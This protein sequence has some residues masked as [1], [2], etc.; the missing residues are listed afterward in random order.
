MNGW[1]AQWW[2]RLRI[3]HKVWAVLL[4]LCVPLGA[5]LATHL[6]VVQQLLMLQQQ[7]H[8]L[9]LAHEQVHVLRR[10]AIDI[11]DG[12]RGY[13]LTQQPAFLVPMTDAV[14]KIEQAL[15]SSAASLAKLPDP[16]N[17][18]GP[19]ER[20]LKDLLRSKHELIADIQRGD[21]E[22][23][24]AYVRS[25]EG[26]QLS[27]RLR[28]EL[29]VIE[30]RLEQERDRLNVKAEALSQ[31]TFIG[32][33]IA[34]AGV[35]V[36]GWIGSRMLARSLTDPIRRLQTATTKLGEQID[37][38]EAAELLRPAVTS[39]DELGQLAHAYLTMAHRIGT[40]IQELEV[41][42]TIGQ[43]INT[44][45]PDG[46]DGVLRRITDRAMEL[47]QADVCLMLVRDER[48]GCWIVEAASGEWNDRLK[49]SVMLWEELPVSV[50]AYES[51]EAAVGEHFREDQR[52]QVVRRNLIG[53]SMLAIP[54]LSQGVPFGVLSLLSRQPRAAFEWN[55]RLAKGLAQEAALAISNARLYEAA[56]EK[57]RGL[58]ARLRHL[59]SLAE[60]LAHDLKGPGARMEELSKLLAQKFSG[61]TDERTAKWLALI[62]EN[63]RDIVR[64]VEGILEVAQVGVGQGTVT[65]VDPRL[66]VDDV[67]KAQAGEIER[68]QA[69]I[70]VESG[71]PL[72]AC[73]GA[74][75]RQ[76][77]DNLVTNALKYARP[78]VPPEVTIS[79]QTGKHM[80]CFAVQDRGIGVPAAQRSRVFQPFVRL[81]EATAPGSGIGLTIVQR[82]VEL[83]GG[84]VW[85]DGTD[86]E[87]C[88]VKFTLPSLN[89]DH[90]V[91]GPEGSRANRHEFVDVTRN[92]VI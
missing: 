24:L 67:L 10:L 88:T 31:R 28:Q 53:D 11:E 32:L 43:E 77:F 84:R 40:H 76:V 42:H 26:L 91:T 50:Q 86:G 78:G 64:R 22:K 89:H 73:H 80:V 16:S 39:Q 27:D 75:L 57:Q 55:Q 35:V 82:I 9:V 21:A 69:T 63:G 12:F 19:V 13:L 70:H 36:L 23:A 83:C 1:A 17:S 20:Q 85:I 44:I 38:A 8:E 87:G 25:G 18:L 81:G 37:S 65:A 2:N 6:Y 48:M 29:R 61:Q 45:G 52:P 71:F 68:L 66:V 49:K 58:K 47:V 90:G 59:E 34:L 30:D 15:S 54:L 33:W 41:L 3:Q 79:S 62:Q 14:A 74:Y 7:R 72:V 51:R 56:Q 60:T 92:D 5:G 46:L 4:L